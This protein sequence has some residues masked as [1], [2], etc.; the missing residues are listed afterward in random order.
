MLVDHTTLSD[1]EVFGSTEGDGG[2]FAL[3]DRTRTNAGRAAL[4]RRVQEPC[5][6]L[7]DVRRSQD[8]V[9]FLWHHPDVLQ[10][11]EESVAP[12]WAYLHSNIAVSKQPPTRVRA[13]YAWMT[14]GFGDVVRELRAGWTRRVV[15]S[16][17]WH[18]SAKGWP[19]WVPLRS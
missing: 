14:I 7:E 13:E 4:R 8:A 9:R 3:L 2:L 19:I 15:S 12:V 1:L 17:T 16:K 5:T 10:L 18:D 6:T 11:R